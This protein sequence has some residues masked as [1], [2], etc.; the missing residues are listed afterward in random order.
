MSF[1]LKVLLIFLVFNIALHQSDARLRDFLWRQIQKLPVKGK[2]EIN[3][4]IYVINGEK[5]TTADPVDSLGGDE[6]YSDSSTT[7]ESLLLTELDNATTSTNAT[8][9]VP[10][11]S[12]LSPITI[13]EETQKTT[14][15]PKTETIYLRPT[16]YAS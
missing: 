5:S 1:V 13:E 11:Q 15:S 16:S 6:D 9:E 8:I 3:D 10:I 2:I 12:T 14:D 7:T 4:K